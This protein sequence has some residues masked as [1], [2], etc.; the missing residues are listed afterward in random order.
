[1]DSWEANSCWSARSLRISSRS[2][3]LASKA[4]GFPI[5]KI[6]AKLAIG[7]TLDELD[8]DITKVTPASFEP[9]IDY[10]VTK[11]PRFTFEKFP[12]A[13][14][15]LTTQMKSVGEAM[16]I[17]RTFQESLQ[18]ALRSLETGHDGLCSLVEAGTDERRLAD[19]RDR[20]AG[21]LIAACPDAVVHGHPELRLPNTLSISFHNLEANRILEAIGLAVA[22]SAGAACHADT[23]EVSHVLK[24]MG[25]PLYWAKGTLRL[26][27]GR[28]TTRS[29]IDTAVRVISKAIKDLGNQHQG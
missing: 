9:T 6:A 20:L 18:K 1:M 12:Q 8:N 28:K 2:S 3:A 13:E 16:A 23:V 5:A 26:T 21:R 19:L 25:T 17:G 24:A 29:D 11:I 15:R 7:Y 4:T 14:N 10:V 27:T 22:A